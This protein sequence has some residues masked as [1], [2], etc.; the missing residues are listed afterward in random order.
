MK[1]QKKAKGKQNKRYRKDETDHAESDYKVFNT[2]KV[3]N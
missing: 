3:R 2:A 1:L